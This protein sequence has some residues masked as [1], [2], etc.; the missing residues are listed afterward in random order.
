MPEFTPKTLAKPHLLFAEL[1]TT[2]TRGWAHDD[3][4]RYAGMRC[5]AA[6]VFNAHG[7][8]VAGISVSGSTARFTEQAI[9]LFSTAVCKAA[10]D[11]TERIGGSTD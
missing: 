6:P 11:L 4:E 9:S 10:A 8:A 5:I 7:D 1:E 2:R 3:E